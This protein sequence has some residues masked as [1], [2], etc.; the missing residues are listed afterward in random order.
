MKIGIDGFPL[1]IPFPCGTKT[2]ANELIKNLSKIDKTNEYLI[3][4]S[5][6][7]LIPK[8]KNF[9]FIKVPNFIPILK[10]QL[11]LPALVRKNHL[12][13]FHF[14]EPYGSFFLRHPKIITTVHDINLN[15]TYP[16]F[17]KSAINRVY[18][19]LARFYIFKN[20]R[21]F[22]VNSD[23]IRKELEH[24]LARLDKKAKT[25]LIPIACQKEFSTSRLNVTKSNYFLCMG[26]FAPRKNIPNVIKAFSLLPEKLRNKIRLKIVCSTSTP[27]KKF[28]LLA[29][30][31]NIS[32]K[33]DTMENV[34]IPKLINLY[35]KAVAFIY[36]SVYEGFG[37]PILE[38]MTLGCPV[39]TSDFGAMK[40]TTADA[41]YAINT[42]SPKAISQAMTEI[43]MNKELSKKLIKKGSKRSNNYSWEI[44]AKKTLETYI[45]MYNCKS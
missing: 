19:E 8:Q 12:D 21:V 45:T 30:N 26:D 28:R 22:I 44:T 5:K 34:S 29:K 31:Y 36:P 11:F 17:S 10:R 32:L 18:C 27:A 24:Y 16:L 3:F 4:A 9:K 42:K 39:I 13:I 33:V 43:L 38:A 25:F 35:S 6:K 15:Y 41:A 14:L 23:F 2:Y 20:T 40:E 37:I 1:T 7:V